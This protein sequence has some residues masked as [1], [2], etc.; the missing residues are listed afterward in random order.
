MGKS[1]GVTW[2]PEGVQEIK[3]KIPGFEKLV[4]SHRG[5]Q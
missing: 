4:T 2:A 5:V 1:G 3:L